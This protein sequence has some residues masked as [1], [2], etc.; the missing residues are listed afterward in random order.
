MKTEKET[1]LLD[2]Q[3]VD[4]AAGRIQDWL[5]EAGAKRRDVLRIR[6]TMEELLMKIGE[7]GSE[8]RRAELSLARRLGTVRLRVRYGGE[9]FDPT[10]SA[11]NEMEELSAS[12]LSRTGFIPAWRWRSGTNELSLKVP[13]PGLRPEYVMLGSIAAAVLIGLLGCRLP[14]AVKTAVTDHALDFL[15]EGFL[16]LLNTFIGLMIFLAIVTG[17]C[18]I[19]SASVFGRI[20][21]LTVT[22][23]I[24]ISFV[25]DVPLVLACR[26][27]FRTGTGGETG[28]SQMRAIL[29]MLFGILP[30]NPVKPFL[31]GNN[32]QIVFIG[33]LVG[34]VILLAGSEAENLRRVA[35]EAQNVVMKCVSLICVFLPVYVFC[36]LVSQLWISGAGIFL[37]LWKP[38]VLSVVMALLVMAVYLVV[39]CRRLKVR[40]GVLL[41]KLMPDFIIGL[42]TS[43]SSAAFATTLEINEKK[44]G[45]DPSFSRTAVPIGSVLYVGVS[46]MFLIFSCVY[47]AEY[48][49]VG[50][51]LA[52]W[53]TLW[54]IGTILTMAVP[55]VAGGGISC[56][57]ILLVQMNVPRDGLAV[58]ITLSMLLD[59]ICTAARIFTMHI[60]VCLLADRLGLLDRDMLQ[61][62]C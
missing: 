44:L 1:I 35:F 28:S 29:E 38:L 46:S 51:N 41:P 22:R 57:T 23:L 27:V 42:S 18:G 60:E 40:L 56:L 25:I 11:D 31:E 17:I 39:A 14:E 13:V 32:L 62:K 53:I 4:E 43:S 3:G 9:K 21:K 58:A 55:P 37:Q 8:A 2:R 36:S 45:V 34:V 50:T 6:L 16:D 54:F 49:Q 7:S 19:G 12:I 24:V 20:G 15:S 10:R 47:A 59:F 33:V 5:T 61:R 48:Y 26:L 52:W 30:S